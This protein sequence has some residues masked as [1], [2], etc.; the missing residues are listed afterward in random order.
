MIALVLPSRFSSDL[1]APSPPYTHP[2]I[3]WW[4]N[5]P[6]PV[7]CR[8][9]CSWEIDGRCDTCDYDQIGLAGLHDINCDPHIPVT[10]Y[11]LRVTIVMKL[12]TTHNIHSIA[13]AYTSVILQTISQ[14]FNIW[15][16]DNTKTDPHLCICTRIRVKERIVAVIEYGTSTRDG[17]VA[18]ETPIDRRV[19]G[20]PLS[21][22]TGISRMKW[23]E[24]RNVRRGHFLTGLD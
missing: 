3:A 15:P 16:Y 10:P 7:G 19:D 9:E 1:V 8:N 21:M 20:C 12:R 13:V 11:D 14:E 5:I 23:G 22:I 2:S 24:I 4:S 17:L 6:K 18:R